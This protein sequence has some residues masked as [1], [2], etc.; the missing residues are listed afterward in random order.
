MT[1]WGAA[2]SGCGCWSCNGR[3][4]E[5]YGNIGTPTEW[6]F[7]CWYFICFYFSL[8]WSICK[9]VMESKY[10]ILGDYYFIELVR[11]K[12]NSSRILSANEIEEKGLFLFFLLPICW[13][14]SANRRQR[15]MVK[16]MGIKKK[17]ALEDTGKITRRT[18]RLDIRID[19]AIS[20]PDILFYF[21]FQIN[22]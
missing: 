20:E 14:P 15:H 5:S 21:N 22:I 1:M 18:G 12:E 7:S 2:H 6:N 19:D 8:D 10:S 16:V 9:T 4:T 13:F 11:G 3:P 17:T